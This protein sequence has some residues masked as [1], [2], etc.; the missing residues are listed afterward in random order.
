MWKRKIQ[1]SEKA[2]FCLS[3]LVFAIRRFDSLFEENDEK[4]LFAS[5]FVER[6]GWDRAVLRLKKIKTFN[7]V[8]RGSLT[9][10][11]GQRCPIVFFCV[12][13]EY[14]RSPHCDN[15]AILYF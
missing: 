10:I 13:N 1:N 9:N 11:L 14:G 12:A 8:L 15:S 7:R 5:M 2:I 4:S 6:C 3:D